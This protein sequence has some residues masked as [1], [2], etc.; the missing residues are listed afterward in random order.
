[1]PWAGD[2]YVGSLRGLAGS[3]LRPGNGSL[4]RLAA[5]ITAP[6]LVLWGRED[7]LVDARLAP[8]TARLIPGSRLLVL[9]GVGHT[10]QMEV[11][12]IVARAVL[13]F[14]RENKPTATV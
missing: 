5:R 13:A 8:R 3:Y 11:P 6:T 7:R 2:A 1:V 9:D 14:L 10:A 4:W 12:R